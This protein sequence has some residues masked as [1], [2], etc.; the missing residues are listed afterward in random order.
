MELNCSARK[1]GQS[2]I[3]MR[4]NDVRAC[5]RACVPAFIPSGHNTQFA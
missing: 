4:S 2:H 1:L 5:V 3:Y